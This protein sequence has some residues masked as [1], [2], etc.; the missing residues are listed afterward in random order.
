MPADGERSSLQARDTRAMNLRRLLDTLLIAFKPAP[1]AFACVVALCAA[2]GTTKSSLH[3]DD[4][5]S[6]WL[7]PSPGLRQQIEDSAKR[8]PWTHGLERVDLISWFAGCG[9][10][11]YPTL[12]QMVLDP[13][14]DVAGAALAAL[15]AT[16]DSRLVDHLRALPWPEG[17]QQSDLALERARTL[18]R[19]GDW[20]MVPVL[21]T[22][23][24]DER[25]MTRALCAQT[26]WE[27]THER[28]GY[29]PRA[30]VPLREESVHRWEGWWQER[31][32][33][34]MQ[35][36]VKSSTPVAPPAKVERG[37]S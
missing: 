21:I 31:L 16:R 26:L 18:L 23:L 32:N 20:H 2:C 27:A 1:L 10:P 25:L 34:P 5:D 6:P 24:S 11:A 29:D 30:E 14:K 35:T 36:A 22:G 3:D 7:K 19:L 9:E 28:F 4:A 37:D 17:E 33:D 15:G 8:L 12:L 13:R